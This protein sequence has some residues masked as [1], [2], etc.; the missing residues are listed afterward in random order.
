[1]KL[2]SSPTSDLPQKDIEVCDLANE[3][4]IAI[5]SL[6]GSEKSIERECL[7]GVKHGFS[8]LREE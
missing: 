8:I 4:G 7:S 3:I 6:A 5:A 2:Y 1:M